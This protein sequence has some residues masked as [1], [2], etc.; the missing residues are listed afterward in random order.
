MKDC[1]CKL[2]RYLLLNFPKQFSIRFRR[3]AKLVFMK[4]GGS[5]SPISPPVASPLM[6]LKVV[7]IRAFKDDYIS[8]K[9]C[10]AIFCFLNYFF[11]GNIYRRGARRW[12][13]IYKINGHSFVARRFSRVRHSAGE[14]I[15]LLQ[16]LTS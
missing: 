12:R 2:L 8:N 9:C 13:K 15:T 4:S 6:L 11:I 14:L 16:L 3:I 5:G 7:I 10:S 1:W